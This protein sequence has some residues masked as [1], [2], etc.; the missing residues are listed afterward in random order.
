MGGGD[1][2]GWE[3]A[4]GNVC[5]QDC[6]CCFL[7]PSA[8]AWLKL[9]EGAVRNFV[10]GL[11]AAAVPVLHVSEPKRN[12]ASLQGTPDP[13]IVNLHGSQLFHNKQILW[14]P[15]KIALHTLM[16]VLCGIFDHPGRVRKACL[17][18]FLQA[19]QAL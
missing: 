14:N 6:S 1:C 17:G 12:A 7:L 13:W 19:P 4:K 16:N 10:R 15:K 2:K 18:T 5:C 3:I 11:D 8:D 9:T